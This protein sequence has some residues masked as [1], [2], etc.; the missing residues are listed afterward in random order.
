M[1]KI[2]NIYMIPCIR[3]SK[4]ESKTFIQIMLV[5]NGTKMKQ[6]L[7]KIKGNQTMAEK[8]R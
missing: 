4:F 8:D 7:I 6:L 3:N 5:N 2:E 1:Q